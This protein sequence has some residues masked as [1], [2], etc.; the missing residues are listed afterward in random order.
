MDKIYNLREIFDFPNGTRFIT[1]FD[2]DD[3]EYSVWVDEDRGILCCS[4][5]ECYITKEWLE[6][7]LK[8]E[9]GII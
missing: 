9:S 7:T 2:N 5:G 1:N 4:E 3:P 6:A 8:L